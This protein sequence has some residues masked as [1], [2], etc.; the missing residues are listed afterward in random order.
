MVFKKFYVCCTLVRSFHGDFIIINKTR[1]FGVAFILGMHANI[2][3]LLFYL[4]YGYN[5][6]PWNFQN[7]I[8]VVVL[9]WSLKTASTFEFFISKFDLQKL[10]MLV[11]TICLPLA[12][13]LF[14]TYDNLLSFHFFTADLK[15]YNVFFNDELKEKLPENIQQFYRYE[16]GKVYVQMNEWAQKDNEVLFYP[17]DRVMNYMDA[18][19]RSF[20]DNPNDPELTTLVDYNAIKK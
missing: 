18:Y 1:K 19:L 4:G 7:M 13:N 10:I 2:V 11:F 6:V 12:N 3:F 8:S 15:Y 16:N 14:G 9:F 5:V 20:A 17:E